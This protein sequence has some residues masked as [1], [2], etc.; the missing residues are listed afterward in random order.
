[1]WIN[2][3]K[4]NDFM[5]EWKVF[6]NGEFISLN[7]LMEKSLKELNNFI[8]DNNLIRDNEYTIK[9]F[10]NGKWETLISKTV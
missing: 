4:F 9:G 2:E 1:M 3:F 6:S 7:T 8:Y 10:R 5:L